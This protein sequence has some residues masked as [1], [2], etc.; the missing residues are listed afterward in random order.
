MLQS[1]TCGY[2]FRLSSRLSTH[3]CRHP[4]VERLLEANILCRPSLTSMDTSYHKQ[5]QLHYKLNTRELKNNLS[6]L[7]VQKVKVSAC[8]CHL[9][10][11][12]YS[13]LLESE[14]IS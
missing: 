7:V 12:V 1:Q 14:L 11:S 4:L 10:K 3:I 9:C 6:G 2:F 8:G 5:L 13:D